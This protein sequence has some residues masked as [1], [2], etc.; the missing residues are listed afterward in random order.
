MATLPELLSSRQPVLLDGGMGTE[1]HRMGVDISLPLWSAH[2]LITA[3]HVVRNIHFWYLHA[4]ADVI[5]TNTFRT[6]IRALRNAGIGERWEELN[7]RAVQLAFEARER[8]RIVRPVAIAGSIAPVEDCYSPWLVPE[9]ALLED[10]HRAQAALLAGMGV[11]VLLAETMNTIREGVAAARAC[12]AT[13]K[14]FAVSWI[15]DAEGR[16]LSGEALQDAAMA[17]LPFDPAAIFV[18][19]VPVTHMHVSLSTLMQTVA[20]PVGCYANT[21]TPTRDGVDIRHDTS[22][23]GYAAIAMSWA[24]AGARL[25]GGC[26]GT[27]PEHIAMICDLVRPAH[28]IQSCVGDEIDPRHGSILPS[29]H[30]NSNKERRS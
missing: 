25:I 24:E 4:G 10:E 9:D 15:C 26:C 19:C 5:T 29:H 30:V 14:D 22:P 20:R 18:N 6:N 2:A 17:V 7:L 12:A 21:G 28:T 23:E 11:D 16:L 1:L 13:G 27:T 8:Y 3:P